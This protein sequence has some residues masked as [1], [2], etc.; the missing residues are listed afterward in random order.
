MGGR[1][2]QGNGTSECGYRVAIA[3]DC[4]YESIRYMYMYVNMSIACYL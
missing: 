4:K 2:P 1:G 3:S